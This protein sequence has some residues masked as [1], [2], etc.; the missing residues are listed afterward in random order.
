MEKFKI[1]E[2]DGYE[3]LDEKYARELINFIKNSKISGAELEIAFSVA[4]GDSPK[5]DPGKPLREE[6]Y[7]LAKMLDEF[8][9]KGLPIA[10]AMALIETQKN[11][12]MAGETYNDMVDNALRIS[13][14]EKRVLKS[15]VDEK[16]FGIL[17]IIDSRTGRM[18]EQ[19]NTSGA[20]PKGEFTKNNLASFLIWSLSRYKNQE[21]KIT[22]EEN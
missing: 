7:A 5:A 22:F 13:D 16:R 14:K 21:L 11:Y 3:I 1:M 15:I 12:E 17:T 10:E 9:A 6:V 2:K 8:T 18:L 20:A 19:V 4:M